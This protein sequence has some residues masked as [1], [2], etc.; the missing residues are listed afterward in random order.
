MPTY[1]IEEAVL[2]EACDPPP[3]HPV[4]DLFGDGPIVRAQGMEY[5]R[6]GER[7]VAFDFGHGVISFDAEVVTRIGD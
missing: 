1:L 4:W 7:L 2:K 5:T 3:D 6:H